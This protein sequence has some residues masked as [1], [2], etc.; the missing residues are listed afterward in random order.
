MSRVLGSTRR[1]SLP[2]HTTRLLPQDPGGQMGPWPRASGRKEGGREVP[3]PRPDVAPVG[4][5]MFFPTLL[6]GMKMALR[7]A[8][9]FGR[10]QTCAGGTWVLKSPPTR[11]TVRTTVCE[12]TEIS[13]FM[14]QSD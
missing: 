7:T 1:K 6:A 9:V 11:W 10:W 3:P 5:S 2:G 12:V 8:A 13:G 14:L 4:R